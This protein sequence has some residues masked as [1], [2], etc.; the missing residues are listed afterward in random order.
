MNPY[1]ITSVKVRNLFN[2]LEAL[3][4]RSKPLG[5]GNFI[6]F[7]DS[8][9]KK[10]KRGR[11]KEVVNKDK[12]QIIVLNKN[13]DPK[14]NEEENFKE[15]N[16]IEVVSSLQN[17]YQFENSCDSEDLLFLSYANE[18]NI[19]NMILERLREDKSDFFLGPILIALRSIS[20][21]KPKAKSLSNT[22]LFNQL[23]KN[24]VSPSY[25]NDMRLSETKF[26]ALILI[27]SHYTGELIN[28]FQINLFV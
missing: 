16:H 20:K 3:D 8:E 14:K 19:L 6:W 17:I 12:I 11:I 10:F 28:K 24:A 7:F 23:I 15:S 21:P 2:P 18:A 26:D 4:Q 25:F 5:R 13:L 1:A 9:K 22:K 27:G